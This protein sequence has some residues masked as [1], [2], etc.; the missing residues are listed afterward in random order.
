MTTTQTGLVTADEL[1]RLSAQGFRGELVRGVLRETMAA[2]QRHG[3]I[4]SRLNFQLG[5]QVYPQRLGTMVASDSG[6]L[7]ERDPDTVREPDIAFTSYERQPPGSLKDGYAE[8][9]PN[10]VVE[11]A[12]PNDR[13]DYPAERSQMWL[14]FGVELVWFVFP[15]TRSIDVYRAG[16]PVV[17][18]SGDGPLDG[19]DVLPG[20]SCPLSDIFDE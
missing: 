8:A 3:D 12:S 18:V 6:V 2:G 5:L 9:V 14:S 19:L 1:L 20:F 17:T 13:R 7:I 16:E 11:V 4:V 10:L 15:E